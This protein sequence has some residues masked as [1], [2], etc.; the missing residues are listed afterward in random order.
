MKRVGIIIIIFLAVALLVAFFVSR[1]EQKTEQ[2]RSPTQLATT[3]VVPLPQPSF[4]TDPLLPSPSY[5]MGTI[6]DT[7]PKTIPIFTSGAPVSLQ[8]EV[9]RVAKIFNVTSAP[10][11][12]TAFDGT[13]YMWSTNPGLMIGPDGSRVSYSASGTTTDPLLPGDS[14]YTTAATQ[15]V[16]AVAQGQTARLSSTLYFAPQLTDLNFVERGRATG[17][18][19]GF[20]A[21]L[22]G[23]PLIAGDPKSSETV[24]R[25]NSGKNL[26]HYAGYIF[27]QFVPSGTT[28]IISLQQAGERLL[29]G[30]GT[31]LSATS[32]T[33]LNAHDT[34]WYQFSLSAVARADLAY[35]YDVPA[36]RLSPVFLFTGKAIDKTTGS[37]VDTVTA[38]SAVP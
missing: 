12:D 21:I 28:S 23:F 18:Q 34:K 9:E 10:T 13:Y 30:Q 15:L 24:L 5:T 3:A 35:Y 33:D 6:A 20:T 26:L 11:I 37:Q 19:L 36:K 32:P 14:A 38:V 25:F 7:F 8:K 2:D 31:V 4:P 27:P 29:A 16:S 22:G 17:I 1:R